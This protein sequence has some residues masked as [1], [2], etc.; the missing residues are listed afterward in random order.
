MTFDAT[1]W[2]AVSFFIFFGALVYLKVPGK[3]NDLLTNMITGI[4]KEIDESEKLRAET[5]SML[6]EAQKKLDTAD[7]EVNKILRQ[8]KDDS[9]KLVIEMNEK[10]HNSS[11]IKKNAAQQ[12]INQMKENAIR[13]IKNTSIKIA[14][15]S[16]Q[17]IITT[18]VDKSKLDNLFDK[19]LEETKAELK[20]INS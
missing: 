11:E 19:N 12:K 4:K 3:I 17:K 1:F 15:E 7:K 9:E 14:V 10:F 8:A 6:D 2:V 13:D 16:V 18:S 20:K 5:K